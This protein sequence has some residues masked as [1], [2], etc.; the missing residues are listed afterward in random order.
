MAANTYSPSGFQTMHR[1][2]SAPSNYATMANYPIAYNYGTIIAN[3]DPVYLTTAGVLNVMANAGTTILG[4]FRGCKYLDPAVGSVR[5]WNYWSAPSGL[6]STTVVQAYVDADP[7][8]EFLC[9][10]TG[11][12]VT[13][14]QIGLNVD[15]VA[16]SSANPI[17]GPSGM[18]QCGLN[19]GSIALTATLPFR[20]ISV[21]GAPVGNPQY[22]STNTN[23][24][25]RVQMNTWSGPA[26]TRTG[27]A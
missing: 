18:S 14:S 23:Q 6:A 8:M 17:Y 20:L 11:T 27:Q 5:W 24:W 19:I 4:I 26:G 21:A 22:V 3:G 16:A 10:G 2:D 7:A 12:A 15:I 9:Q 25:L 13:Q 1:Y